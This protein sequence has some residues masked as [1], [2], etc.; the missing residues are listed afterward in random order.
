MLHSTQTT[1]KHTGNL[2][3]RFGMAGLLAAGLFFSAP[4][5]AAAETVPSAENTDAGE[6]TIHFTH[7]DAQDLEFYLNTDQAALAF[8]D[9]AL[10]FQDSTMDAP[11][12]MSYLSDDGSYVLYQN[13]EPVEEVNGTFSVSMV[14]EPG[15]TL[16]MDQI[17]FYVNGQAVSNGGSVVITDSSAAMTSL[18]YCTAIP[19]TP[20]TDPEPSLPEEPSAPEVPEEPAAPEPS[21]PEQPSA[22][23]ETP[24][25][26]QPSASEQPAQENI[27]PET[28]APASK[29]AP[30]QVP[31]SEPIAAEPIAS[32]VVT[33]DEEVDLS[34]IHPEVTASAVTSSSQLPA[35]TQIVPSVRTTDPDAQIITSETAA[36]ENAAQTE[37]T[38]TAHTGIGS[39]FHQ[40]TNQILAVMIAVIL[41]LIL[42]E[43]LLALKDSMNLLKI[44]SIIKNKHTK[45]RNVSH[46]TWDTFLLL[47][48]F[49]SS[50][51]RNRFLNLTEIVQRLTADFYN[52]TDV[53]G[54]CSSLTRLEADRDETDFP[55]KI[56]SEGSQQCVRQIVVF[57][58]QRQILGHVVCFH[59]TERGI[60]IRH[61]YVEIGPEHRAQHFFH[62][63]AGKAVAAACAVSE[64]GVVALADL[65]ELFELLRIGLTVGIGLEDI[66]RTV[67]KCIAVAVQNGGTVA[68]VWLRQ[69][70]EQRVG[71]ALC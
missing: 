31:A 24:T 4:Y 65:P 17:S 23:A 9:A 12:T 69:H 56:R 40:R 67:F 28:A 51:F 37:N 1:K 18:V 5:S 11:V 62:D 50:F 64:N 30:E 10:T 16:D 44:R 3:L 52:F 59:Q 22:P 49:L 36:L 58:H 33:E 26:V 19:E 6:I 29:T 2:I 38:Q 21:V 8:T 13:S 32:A 15:Y 45:R 42:I 61:G 55:V 7:Y 53:D 48:Y 43:S 20:A 41:L 27:L 60:C 57:R 25:V 46:E 39:W 70:G 35:A 71:F 14:T 34:T 47:Y 63:S 66:V 54:I 68:A